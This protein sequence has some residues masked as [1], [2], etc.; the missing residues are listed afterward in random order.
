MIEID[1]VS[2]MIA[3]NAFG[4]RLAF[5]FEKRTKP[6]IRYGAGSIAEEKVD[7]AQKTFWRLLQYNKAERVGA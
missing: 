3:G 4:A 5:L 6:Y 2:W 7:I 1:Y